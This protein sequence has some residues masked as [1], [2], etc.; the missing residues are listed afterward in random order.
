MTEKLPPWML[1]FAANAKVLDTLKVSVA[2]I[3]DKNLRREFAWLIK[4]ADII[5]EY[6]TARADDT[7]TERLDV[8]RERVLQWLQIAK[9]FSDAY[10]MLPLELILKN[11]LSA[12][13]NVMEG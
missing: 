10:S 5:R 6:L 12:F 7:V 9:R 1:A 8:V 4:E 2:S 3:G 13:I 11:A